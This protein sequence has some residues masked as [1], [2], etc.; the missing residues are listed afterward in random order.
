VAPLASIY[1][2]KSRSPA[3]GSAGPGPDLPAGWSRCR[4]LDLLCPDPD[5]NGRRRHPGVADRPGRIGPLPAILLM[6]VLGLVN[7]VTIIGAA[8]AAAR[9]GT[10]RYG[11]GF[12]GRMVREYLA[13]SP[14]LCS[15][16][17]LP[18]SAS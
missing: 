11:S 10:V 18:C 6:I 8:E 16:W 3:S 13:A 5:G 1:Q 9:S 2:G 17:P 4:L 12:M 14:A 15:L 7:V